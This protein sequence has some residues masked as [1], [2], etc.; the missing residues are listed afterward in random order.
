[1]KPISGEWIPKQAMEIRDAIHKSILSRCDHSLFNHNSA[2]CD[3]SGLTGV[4]VY[5]AIDAHCVEV[6]Q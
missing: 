4:D 2:R 3:G 5:E 6:D 1:M